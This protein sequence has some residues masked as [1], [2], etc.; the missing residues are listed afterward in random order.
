MKKKVCYMLSVDTIKAI[1]VFCA[2]RDIKIN[3]LVEKAII[4]YIKNNG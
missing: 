2:L 3:E 1:K 4:E